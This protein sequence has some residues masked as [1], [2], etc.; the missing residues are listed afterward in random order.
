NLDYNNIEIVESRAFYGSSIA[1]LSL[2]GNRKLTTIADDAFV[3]LENLW[4]LDLSETSITKLPTKGLESIEYLKIME[5]Y[6]LKKF[7]SVYNFNQIKEAHLTYAYHCCAFKY[8]R[9]H[10]PQ[11]YADY[12]AFMEKRYCSTPS[13]STNA[14]QTRVTKQ[15]SKD[16][17]WPNFD[18]GEDFG[19]FSKAIEKPKDREN[20]NEKVFSNRV[21]TWDLFEN[22][23]NNTTNHYEKNGTYGRL[24]YSPRKNSASNTSSWDLFAGIL[25]QPSTNFAEVKEILNNNKIGDIWV[26]RIDEATEIPKNT[27]QIYCGEFVRYYRAV[28]CYPTP[29][30]FNPCEDVM[31]N[32]L[33]RIAVWF[34]VIAAVSG[35]AAVMIV[36]MSG[37]FAM[38]VSKFLMCNLA[39]A[40]FCMGLYLLIIAVIDVRTI[41]VYF[42]YAIDWQHG[43][44]CK[45]AGFITVFASELSIF[46]LTVIT[47]ERWYA[48][49]YAIHLNRR[50]KL[51][52]AVKIMIGGWVYAIAMASLPL[53]GVS[54]YTKTS[55]C[56]PMENKNAV[57][58]TYLVTLLTINALAFV[59]I[60]AC[61]GKMYVSIVG[62][63]TRA[64][65]SDTAVAKR[66]ALL[67]FT[68]F[69][70][71][72]PIAFFGLTAVFGYPLIN[73][74]NS[75]IL[76]VFF[77]PLNSCAN[78]FLYG[79]CTKRAM[80]YKGT[81]SNH[82]G[83]HRILSIK[84]R[85]AAPGSMLS[86]ASYDGRVKGFYRYRHKGHC[87]SGSGEENCGRSVMYSTVDLYPESSV[88]NDSSNEIVRIGFVAKD[89]RR[90]EGKRKKRGKKY[91][92]ASSDDESNSPLQRGSHTRLH[93]LP[94]IER[95]EV[96][97]RMGVDHAKHGSGVI[98][99]TSA[100]LN[101]VHKSHKNCNFWI[102]RD[103]SSGEKSTTVD[104]ELL[105]YMKSSSSRYNAAENVS[106]VTSSQSN[107]AEDTEI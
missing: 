7:P 12:Q 95:E 88:S 90:G 68:D 34:V 59:L 71:W 64:T 31:G 15:S 60:S 48:I 53:F 91:A 10:D 5:T 41:G 101:S 50:L 4:K 73:V 33:L 2:K 45:I 66:M 22:Y 80:K 23:R 82:H 106:F 26:G 93:R 74:T 94:S 54:S 65:M 19:V 6:T 98:W 56:L 43:F 28:K 77:Y 25:G 37:R 38:S 96:L 16:K 58:V 61:Y 40:D 46:T 52:L 1:Q 104:G 51:D 35:N 79:F 83:N 63:Q 47:L 32:I 84:G 30:A 85:M 44:G 9:T 76:L 27:I 67:V 103:S 18:L 97:R 89:E 14:D 55:I 39:F 8:P 57:D 49:T 29:D 17:L 62:Q 75:K 42:N 86:Q 78:P 21:D 87:C 13:P 105:H 3:G 36:L 24:V 107:S 72:A 92:S 100:S 81:S 99:T 70:C 20:Q 102:Q 11:H 69:A